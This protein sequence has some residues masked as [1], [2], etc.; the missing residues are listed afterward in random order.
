MTTL[1]TILCLVGGVVIFGVGVAAYARSGAMRYLM[2]GGCMIVVGLILAGKTSSKLARLRLHAA[3]RKTKHALAAAIDSGP[4]RG[5]KSHQ[6]QS[7]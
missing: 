2:I 6:T 1:S 5:K 4:Y 3:K 7:F